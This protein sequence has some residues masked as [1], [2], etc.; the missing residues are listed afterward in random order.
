MFPPLAAFQDKKKGKK[1]ETREP[2]RRIEL[3]LYPVLKLNNDVRES[4]ERM[5]SELLPL[6]DGVH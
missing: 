2:T 6:P 3:E 4:G 1:K 5:K